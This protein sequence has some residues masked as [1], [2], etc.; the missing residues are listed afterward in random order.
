M[1]YCDLKQKF[2]STFNLNYASSLLNSKLVWPIYQ[3][4]NI[5]K[6]EHFSGIAVMNSYFK[7]IDW[8]DWVFKNELLTLSRELKL[9][10]PK[11]TSWDLTKFK[12][13]IGADKIDEY[14]KNH[15]LTPFQWDV[16][17]VLADELAKHDLWIEEAYTK[18]VKDNFAFWWNK[19][20]WYFTYRLASY[21]NDVERWV[22]NHI[23]DLISEASKDVKYAN[24]A[25]ELNN[26]KSKFDILK[27]L[28]SW[29]LQDQLIV[30]KDNAFLRLFKDWES[31]N[32]PEIWAKIF[33]DVEEVSNW[34]FVKIDDKDY[35]N[36]IMGAF[37]NEQ[38]NL[39]WL[40]KYVNMAIWEWAARAVWTAQ[41]RIFNASRWLS[42]FT[43]VAPLVTSTIG[44][45]LD[46]D[47]AN[48][49]W[50]KSY[51]D[52]PRVMEDF[53]IKIDEEIRL[54]VWEYLFEKWLSNDRTLVDQVV[55]FAQDISIY[56]NRS[57]PEIMESFY[58]YVLR[59]ANEK[60]YG[61]KFLRA[62][63]NVKNWFQDI[64]DLVNIAAVKK[65]AFEMATRHYGWIDLINTRM[66]QLKLDLDIAKNSWNDELIKELQYNIDL[67]KRQ[68]NTRYR[69]SMT[70]L[71]GIEQD[72][73]LWKGKLYDAIDSIWLWFQWGWW[74]SKVYHTV[75]YNYDYVRDLFGYLLRWEWKKA[76]EEWLMAIPNEIPLHFIWTTVQSIRLNS[77]MNNYLQWF[78]DNREDWKIEDIFDYFDWL[79][80]FA[81]VFQWFQANAVTRILIQWARRISHLM[82]D[83]KNMVDIWP[84]SVDVNRFEQTNK[85]IKS[86]FWE[87]WWWYRSLNEMVKL[88]QMWLSDY[89]E[90]RLMKQYYFKNMYA[91]YNDVDIVYDTP[92]SMAYFLLG[93]ANDVQ[94]AK[95]NQ[96]NRTATQQQIIDSVS[97]W[98]KNLYSWFALR[99]IANSIT[100]AKPFMS[101][102]SKKL[103]EWEKDYVEDIQYND[104]SQRIQS[105]D[106]KWIYS[107]IEN[108]WSKDSTEI[109]N[110]WRRYVFAQL[111]DKNNLFTWIENV[112]D[113]GTFLSA[114][115]WTAKLKSQIL[116]W[117]LENV[118]ST[119]YLD[120]IS[121][122]YAT[123]V[124]NID[125]LF[126]KEYADK[127]RA[128]YWDLLDDP[129]KF[130]VFLEQWWKEWQLADIMKI[131][132]IDYKQE[133]WATVL[134]QKIAT[135]HFNLL[136][137]WNS[138]IIDP[139][140]WWV[141][142]TKTEIMNAYQEAVA[143]W[144]DAMVSRIKDAFFTKKWK[145][146]TNFSKK[147]MIDDN[148]E[149]IITD[150]SNDERIKPIQDY[151]ISTYMPYVKTTNLP[152][153]WNILLKTDNAVN[154]LA[155]NKK[156]IGS[157]IYQSQPVREDWT[158]DYTKA[159][160][161]NTKLQKYFEDELYSIEQLKKWNIDGFLANYNPMWKVELFGPK[162]ASWN[163]KP[164]SEWTDAERMAV[165]SSNMYM[166]DQAFKDIESLP[167]SDLH[168]VW[169]YSAVIKKWWFDT[170]LKLETMQWKIPDLAQASFEQIK[171]NLFA[172]ISE[173]PEVARH[174]ISDEAAR[175][176]WIPIWWWSGTWGSWKWKSWKSKVPALKKSD[177]DLLDEFT[178]LA[179]KVTRFKDLPQ[180]PNAPKSTTISFSPFEQ[181][182][183]KQ[184]RWRTPATSKSY[185]KWGKSWAGSTVSKSVV[186]WRR[187][188]TRSK[189]KGLKA[190]ALS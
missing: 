94:K 17:L 139:R 178:K 92:G 13:K 164:Q 169:A 168:K 5:A 22:N 166:L 188:A 65:S 14:F 55:R 121:S 48:F 6:V 186:Y 133:W 41:Q 93:S 47:V 82:F 184:S 51:S 126:W 161:I 118:S 182:F 185:D 95:F 39:Q 163:T 40:V 89:F 110:W 170:M 167:I 113:D 131:A 72:Y 15:R 33:N 172:W 73:A 58:D 9:Q 105:N 64:A 21:A 132:W 37:W 176:S 76:I 20:Q 62:V 44:Y 123:E 150:A 100:I 187:N 68:V 129:S 52:I 174:A 180:L 189:K 7:Y 42:W 99:S 8:W 63:T 83:D 145:W 181:R 71:S 97:Q 190:L 127:I 158:I 61:S 114:S 130:K 32:N 153:Y 23:D 77:F 128:K 141:K 179:N 10:L 151:I 16:D 57:K 107:L 49:L 101:I 43:S 34:R 85:L 69:M 112:D 120:K 157:E 2:T 31:I 124:P 102:S 27:H 116:D 122:K 90:N 24:T 88:S 154:Y 30:I 70:Y 1:A 67:M 18:S 119:Q 147:L 75:K 109:A 136:K 173:I 142:D 148:W 81:S 137:S 159:P 135:H 54:Q 56:S 104:I 84:Y 160:K 38:R 86:T 125:W 98:Q 45:K 78:E 80:R 53:W 96:F 46:L 171:R 79:S 144:N 74:L 149:Y 103:S 155:N 146:K 29:K 36:Y 162:D 60:W 66:T 19:L 26:V 152:A 134:L 156:W 138:Y 25:S 35:Q 12:S 11:M 3:T 175:L 50:L 111:V 115:E 59:Y 108:W 28:E 87:I 140:T 106:V 183:I 91:Q 4:M 117:F 177:L 143:Q 165:A